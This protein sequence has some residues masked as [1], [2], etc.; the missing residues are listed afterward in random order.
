MMTRLAKKS[1][2]AVGNIKYCNLFRNFGLLS[3]SLSERRWES[4][5]G[6]SSL[7]RSR[8]DLEVICNSRQFFDFIDS[9][10]YGLL[11][12]VFCKGNQSV[13]NWEK[14]LQ[15]LLSE[16]NFKV[17]PACCTF[18]R[19]CTTL[20]VQFCLFSFR[21]HHAINFFKW[22]FDICESVLNRGR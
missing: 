8:S 21:Q 3:D 13:N 18:S 10:I 2:T 9:Q 11:P 6:T 12:Y 16:M 22:I 17:M 14:C 5:A 4:E 7:A 20:A 19:R 1:K 15:T